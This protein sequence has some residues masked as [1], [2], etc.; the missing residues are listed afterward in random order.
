MPHDCAAP[1]CD[2]HRTAYHVRSMFRFPN[3]DP[4]RLQKVLHNLRRPD[5]VPTFTQGC[6]KFILRIV[7]L[8]D[9]P[10]QS[11]VTK[12]KWKFHLR[13]LIWHPTQFQ[14]YSPLTFLFQTKKGCRRSVLRIVTTS[15][16]KSIPREQTTGS[17]KR[18]SGGER[19]G[20]N[21]TAR[22]AAR[23]FTRWIVHSLEALRHDMTVSAQSW[24][25]M[26]HADS[27]TIYEI[28]QREP[29]V[30]VK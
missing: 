12:R 16:E 6:V 15:Q 29:G 13:D 18:T 3:S 23:S 9:Q 24:R 26:K 5:F 27:A 17:W 25:W 2:I 28:S 1:E 7:V 21:E 20:G 4:S 30:N 14:R 19:G 8:F 11:V 10:V 22:K